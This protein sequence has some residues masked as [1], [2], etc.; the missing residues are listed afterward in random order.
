MSYLDC[1][2]TAKALYGSKVVANRNYLVSSFWGHVPHGCSVNSG[3]DWA[4]HYNWAHGSGGGFTTVNKPSAGHH[5]YKAVDNCLHCLELGPWKYPTAL[6][7]V[8]C[9]SHAQPTGGLARL[10]VRRSGSV[11]DTYYK[12]MKRNVKCEAKRKQYCE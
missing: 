11:I 6:V 8:P 4:A 7:E 3:G 10:E 2:L 5:C 12:D 1:L 9:S